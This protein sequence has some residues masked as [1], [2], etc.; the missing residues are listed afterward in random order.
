MRSLA[1]TQLGVDGHPRGVLRIGKPKRESGTLVTDPTRWF[2]P[3]GNAPTRSVELRFGALGTRLRIAPKWCLA[4]RFIS[5]IAVALMAGVMG[6]TTSAVVAATNGGSA[7]ERFVIK[8]WGTE[9]GL[10]QNSVNVILQTRDGYLWLGTQGGVARFDGV[11]FAVFGLP[12]GLPSI[13]VRALCEDAKGDVWIGT[14]GGGLSRLRD[15]HF[16]TFTVENGLADVNVSALAE[17]AEE[18]MWVGTSA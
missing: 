9:A 2:V 13:Q 17:D 16:E 7:G 1:A 18:R 6:I 15:V 4:L 8:S 5:S 11:R 12:E 14:V 10:P 3:L